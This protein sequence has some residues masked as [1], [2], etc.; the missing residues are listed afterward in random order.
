M[1][2]TGSSA[3]DAA[4]GR[5]PAEMSRPCT[6]TRTGFVEAQGAG[7]VVLMSASAALECGAPVYG[8]LAHSASATDRQ[9]VSLPAPGKGIMTSASQSHVGS[10]SS[11]A[12]AD[13]LLDLE[14][15]REQLAQATRAIDA[16]AAASP[17]GGGVKADALRRA[18]LDVW[19]ADFWHGIPEISPLRGSLAAWGL[20]A[21]DIGLASFH[22][23]GTVSN[24]L[25]ETMVLNRQMEH[26]G[27]SPG[28]AIPVVAQKWLTG[29]PKGPAGA[30]M[31]NSALQSM[32]TGLIPGNRNADNIDARLQCDYAVFPSRT[33]RTDKVKACL[34]KSFGF[35]Q[36]GAEMLVIH[37]DYFLATL[38]AE[39]LLVYSEK[40]AARNRAAYRYWQDTFAGNHTLV[41]VKDSP[42]YAA[43]QEEGVLLNPLARACYNHETNEYVIK[44]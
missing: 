23:T 43:D 37:P 39:Q 25:N 26:L 17:A 40:V 8:V 28:L 32:R 14:H 1:G 20:T 19:G 42:P 34:L 10:A 12:R 22:G 35:G 29:H 11:A 9:G 18:A 3:D 27:R 15:R 33:L 16:L 6:S 30:W 13:R 31:L 24:D 5:H 7:V 44:P 21:D 2:A 41:Q 36:V 38:D 4:A